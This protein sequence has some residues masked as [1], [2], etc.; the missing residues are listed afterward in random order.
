[1]PVSKVQAAVTAERRAN[2]IKLRRAGVRFEDPRIL[3]LG[4]ASRGAA[5]KDF[6]RALEE[7]RDEQ[8]AE[9]SVY[10]QEATE[11]IEALI[12]AHWEAATSG[13]DP[14]SAELVLK[15]M[16]RQAKLNGLDMPVQTEL[17]GPGGGALQVGPVGI[18]QLRNLIRTAGDPDPDDT[19]EE[20]PEDAIDEDAEDDSD[21]S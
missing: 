5:T 20:A 15:L 6:V 9:A 13:E 11:R 14:K 8:A 18:A 4:Y 7:R 2:L 21:D 3:E 19:D 1:M 17:S 12:E 16:D 10:R